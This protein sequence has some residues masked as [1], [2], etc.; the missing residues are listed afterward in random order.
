VGCGCL[1][2]KADPVQSDQPKLVKEITVVEKKQYTSDE[3]A[4][5]WVEETPLYLYSDG[6]VRWKS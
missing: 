6:S 4:A 2:E 3:G 5:Q 1:W